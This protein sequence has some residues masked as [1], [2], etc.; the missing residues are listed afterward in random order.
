MVGAML[1]EGA[2]D[3]AED[4]LFVTLISTMADTASLLF[5][6]E[7]D[8]EPQTAPTDIP[9][10]IRTNSPMTQRARRL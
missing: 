1:V 6:E 3:G 5:L 2:K 10:T 8:P 9:A 7:H 4:G